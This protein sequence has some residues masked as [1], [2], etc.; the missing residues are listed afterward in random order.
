MNSR[1]LLLR[2]AA[3]T[4]S[5][6]EMQAFGTAKGTEKSAPA[7]ERYVSGF[8]LK[9]SARSAFGIVPISRSPEQSSSPGRERTASVVPVLHESSERQVVGGQQRSPSGNRSRLVR[10]GAPLPLR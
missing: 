10:H 6:L 7:L 2:W 3:S 5:A 1:R 8:L 4:G 9:L